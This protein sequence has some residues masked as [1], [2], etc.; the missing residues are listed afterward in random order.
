MLDDLGLLFEY[1]LFVCVRVAWG[2]WGVL[3]WVYCQ[4]LF[5]LGCFAN[6]QDFVF[7]IVGF[8]SGC[9]LV[10]VGFVSEFGVLLFRLL[11]CVLLWR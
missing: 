7:D 8:V 10:F 1:D 11:V 2:V 5:A 6:A 4:V 3:M 9:G